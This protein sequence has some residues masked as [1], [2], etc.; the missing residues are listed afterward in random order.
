M[1]RNEWLTQID[2]PPL[3]IL[4]GSFDPVHRGHLW[5]AEAVY[6]LLPQAEI[7]FMPTAGSPFKQTQTAA[8]HRRAMLRHALR[9][10]P[11]QA[12]WRE[13]KQVAPVFT[14]D[15]LQAIRQ[16]VGQARSIIWIAGLDAL[17]SLSRWKGG[18]ELLSL[19]HFWAFPRCGIAR[20]TVW[21]T[22]LA[23]C[24]V[25]TP[26]ALLKR[27]A[28]RLFLDSR[29]PPEI[30]SSQIRTHPEAYRDLLSPRVSAYIES[31]HLYGSKKTHVH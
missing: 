3:V 9:D 22:E 25:Q 27:P 30:S 29:M 28:G 15:T 21:P 20:P 7:R 4:G 1:R 16:Q 18:Y 14:W 11:F 26:Q 19:T 8:R 12:D 2:K 23:N 31:S 10:T 24:W 5:L 6:Q 13:I 17:L